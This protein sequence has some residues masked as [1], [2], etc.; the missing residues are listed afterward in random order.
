MG[1]PPETGHKFINLAAAHIAGGKRFCEYDRTSELA[2][3]CECSF[4]P[5]SISQYKEYLGYAIW[6]YRSLKE[7]FPALQLV[8]P[9]KSGVFPWEEGYD[10]RF[11]SL[12]R[13]LNVENQEVGM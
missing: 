2:E 13:L 7:P 1:L 11:L 3:G 6:F 5:I 9:D 8:W 10:E 12:Q 4:V